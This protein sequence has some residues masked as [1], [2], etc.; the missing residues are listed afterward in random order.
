M[1]SQ[2]KNGQSGLSDIFCATPCL[3]KEQLIG[4]AEDRMSP[5]QRHRAERHL[6]DCEL[7]STALEGVIST[8]DKD[9]VRRTVNSI[10]RDI[11]GRL[12]RPE[13]ARANWKVYYSMAAILIVGIFTVF[14]AFLRRPVHETLFRQ[15]YQPYPNTIPLV[16]SQ[17][18]IGKLEL[19]M[20]EYEAEHYQ[21][22]LNILQEIIREEPGNITAHFYA[23]ISNL[24]L[25]KPLPAIIL[26]QKVL[27]AERGDFS[28]HA[29]W[30]L[31]LA[32]LR[33]KDKKQASSIFRDI[34]AEDGIHKKQSEEL[35]IALDGKQ[36]E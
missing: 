17:T 23:G 25:D 6:I 36:G 33:S 14:Y 19:A 13:V 30:Y 18:Q 2:D 12:K 8:A 26:L 5:E 4:Y 29:R 32:Y 3:T 1:F 27:D 28:D 16:R 9:R 15:Y 20:M 35:L 10:N 7:C 11:H 21:T 31:G 34:V 22:S 24:C